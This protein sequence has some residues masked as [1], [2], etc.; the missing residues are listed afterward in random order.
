[1]RW[2]LCLLCEIVEVMAMTLDKALELLH[3]SN[4]GF[5]YDVDPARYT[6]KQTELRK[7]IENVYEQGQI[8]GVKAR[9]KMFCDKCI[10]CK[11]WYKSEHDTEPGCQFYDND[12]DCYY[13]E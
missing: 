3:K 4:C 2:M 10:T 11:Y 8:D 5:S 1:M 12:L 6:L 7:L 13:E 9:K